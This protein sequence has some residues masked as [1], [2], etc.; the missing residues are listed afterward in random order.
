MPNLLLRQPRLAH[1]MESFTNYQGRRTR[2]HPCLATAKMD[3]AK[4]RD[5]KAI[6]SGTHAVKNN[7]TN[8]FGH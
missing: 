5:L 2:L 4:H 8:T 7:A 3:H 1:Q 6:I